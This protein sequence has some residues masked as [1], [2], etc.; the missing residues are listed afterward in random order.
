VERVVSEQARAWTAAD[1]DELDVLVLAFVE[2]FYDHRERCAVCGRRRRS[3][4][5]T[6]EAFQAILDWRYRRA[7]RSRAER[8]ALHSL[9]FFRRVLRRLEAAA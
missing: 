8:E 6:L 3:C 4:A 9:L 1:Q 7:L 2:G 5:H